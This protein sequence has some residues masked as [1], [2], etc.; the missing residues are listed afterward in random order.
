V[1]QVSPFSRLNASVL[2]LN[3][4]QVNVPYVTP[5][6][7]ANCLATN[8]SDYAVQRGACDG[9]FLRCL[10]FLY[11]YSTSNHIPYSLI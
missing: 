8:R 2:T 5:T 4:P 10:V 3:L 1:A 11:L 7:N 9:K 6:S